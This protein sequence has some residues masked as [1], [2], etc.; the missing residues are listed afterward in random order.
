MTW[1]SP[2]GG[3]VYTPG[4]TVLGQW[5]ALQGDLDHNTRARIRLCLSDGSEQDCGQYVSPAVQ[6][7]TEGSYLAL[8]TA[9]DVRAPYAFHLQ[10]ETHDHDHDTQNLS[11]VFSIRPNYTV[12]TLASTPSNP[13]PI[14][15]IKSTTATASPSGPAPISIIKSPATTASFNS[16]FLPTS[17]PNQPP[18]IPSESSSFQAAFPS[19]VLPAIAFHTQPPRANAALSGP[20]LKAAVAVPVSLV[21]LILFVSGVVLVLL[22]KKNGHC[23][24]SPAQPEKSDGA[25]WDKGGIPHAIQYADITAQGSLNSV[26]LLSPLPVRPPTARTNLGTLRRAADV[27]ASAHRE[28]LM[29]GSMRHAPLPNP[30]LDPA[31]ALDSSASV[32]VNP[33]ARSQRVLGRPARSLT[34]TNTSAKSEL[35]AGNVSGFESGSGF[36]A[37]LQPTTSGL[38]PK[39]KKKRRVRARARVPSTES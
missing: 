28:F 3:D 25:F 24:A 35:E 36:S 29:T 33:V 4:D 31:G 1:T 14:N 13:A 32:V 30:F 19:V 37:D 8:L 9:P 15:I 17:S 18:E 7:S 39:P 34:E 23:N 5:T 12:S 11:P 27:Q 38:T 16:V 20:M 22:R 10:I 26:D 2:S 21:L 6:K